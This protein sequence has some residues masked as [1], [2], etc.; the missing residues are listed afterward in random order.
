MQHNTHRGESTVVDTDL[1]IFSLYFS[2]WN[3]LILQNECS[4]VTNFGFPQPKLTKIFQSRQKFWR[5]Y[6]I[7]YYFTLTVLHSCISF[8]QLWQA[9]YARYATLVRFSVIP[10]CNLVKATI[11]NASKHSVVWK[12]ASF[13]PFR[14]SSLSKPARCFR[15]EL[16]PSLSF[17]PWVISFL[18]S[19]LAS[20]FFTCRFLK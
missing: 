9:N 15:Y 8:L 5:F 11:F 4:S 3:E 19:S 18:S 12:K 17:F 16:N 20:Y 2:F 13:F 14:G 7:F 10:F 1:P 6:L